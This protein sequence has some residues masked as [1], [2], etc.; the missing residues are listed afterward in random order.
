KKLA[1]NEIAKNVAKGSYVQ[2]LKLLRLTKPDVVEFDQRVT[3]ASLK[4]LESKLAA[5]GDTKGNATPLHAP[6]L[7]GV[8]K[9]MKLFEET[10]Q[11]QRILYLVSDFR[12]GD[13]K[14]SD[15]KLQKLLRDMD[16][17]GIN[18]KMVDVAHPV[19]GKGDADLRYHDNLA[20]TGL[21]PD[22]SVA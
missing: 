18:I 21:R 10:P 15:G 11:D 12:S 22:M 2:Q 4:E 3:E 1:A 16:S 13:W 7:P 5:M 17:K 6:L 8:E 20:I 14:G 19:R 9:A